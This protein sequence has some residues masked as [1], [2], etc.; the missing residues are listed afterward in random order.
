M[1]SNIPE[2]RKLQIRNRLA[3]ALNLRNKNPNGSF[4]DVVM[5]DAL[6]DDARLMLSE[7]SDMEERMRAAA[8]RSVEQ[9]KLLG[10]V[11]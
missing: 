4:H 8:R 5:L 6:L 9:M 1:P 2:M 10:E 7:I 11:Q 3:E